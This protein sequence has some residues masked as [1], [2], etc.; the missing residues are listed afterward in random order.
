MELGFNIISEYINDITSD[1]Y[2]K[3]DIWISEIRLYNQSDMSDPGTGYVGTSDAFFHDGSSEI[4]LRHSQGHIIFHSTDILSVFNRILDVFSFYASWEAKV[5]AL[6]DSGCTLSDLLSLAEEILH[7]PMLVIDSSQ[8]MI[9]FSPS[10]IQLQN[11]DDW[12]LMLYKKSI[13]PDVLRNFN[14]IY[15]NTFSLKGVFHLPADFFPT[16]SCC[17]NIFIEQELHATLIAVENDY[18]TSGEEQLITEI[19]KFILSWLKEGIDADVS[20]SGTSFFAK[21]L[22]GAPGASEGLD[23]R[24]SLFGWEPHC[25]KAI[26]LASPVSESIHFNTYLS[27]LILDESGGIYSIPYRDCVVILYRVNMEEQEIFEK[28]LSS[29]LKHNNYYCAKSLMF[30]ET[31]QI[32]TAYQQTARAIHASEKDGGQIIYCDQFSMEYITNIVEANMPISLLHQLPMQIRKYDEE[33]NTE[34]YKTLFYYLRS[35][36]NHQATAKALI[37]H[38]NTLFLRLQKIRELWPI[39]YENDLMRFHLL[40]SFYHLEF[41][42]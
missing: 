30:T 8:F 40:Y 20:H 18:L 15:K 1:V 27:K 22:D 36:R 26:Y 9:G 38:R 33:N 5:N 32:S 19:G 25:L 7:R 42:Q 37:V 14:Q 3:S 12:D 39:D 2:G 35:E 4:V 28:H 23:R 31:D 6:I 29:V 13:K 34:Y 11:S 16:P 10:F 17:K 41:N 21:A 24:L